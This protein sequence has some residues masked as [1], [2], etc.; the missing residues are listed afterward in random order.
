MALAL[1]KTG[2]TVALVDKIKKEK[3]D[4]I[5]FDPRTSTISRTS[6][7]MLDVLGLWKELDN[8]SNPILDIKVE[9]GGPKNA[10]HFSRD[11]IPGEPMGYIVENDKL[12][13]IIFN[14]IREKTNTIL[15]D[16]FEQ[17][18]LELPFHFSICQEYHLAKSLLR[19]LL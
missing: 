1:S 18:L 3:L 13:K 8:F 19:Q 15:F 17:L 7:I 16:N 4:S 2:A 14:Q 6:K 10:I 11:L 12:R 9:E 5:G